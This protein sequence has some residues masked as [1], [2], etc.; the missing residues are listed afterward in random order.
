MKG[1]LQS[2]LAILESEPDNERAL[3]ALEALAPKV[4]EG[5]GLSLEAASRALGT[6]RRVHRERSDWDLVA[7]L[8]DLEL[9]WT[10]EPSRRADLLYE[11]GRV[12]SDELLRDREAVACFEKVLELRP[13]DAATHE[14]LSN[15]SLVRENWE[16]I[17]TR[18]LTE[19][20]QAQD[21]QLAT[22]LY[23]SAAELYIKNQP[24]A[25]Q[26]EAFLRRAL[27]LDPRN[28]KAAAHLERRL[29]ARGAWDE[30]GTLLARRAEGAGSK[31]ERVQA[32]IALAELEERRGDK[33]KTLEAWRRVLSV[34]AASPRALRALVEALTSDAD[35]AALVKVYEAALKA[36]PRGEHEAALVLQIGMLYWKKLSDLDSAEA[37]FRRVRK[38]E[39]SHPVALEFYRA[40]FGARGE[41]Q[42]L[43]AVLQAAAK[44]ETDPDRRLSLAV[45]MARGAEQEAGATEKAIDLWKAVL[46]VDAAG[47]A[48]VH[49]TEASAALRRLYRKTEKWNAL[50][51]LLKDEIESLPADKKAEKIALHLEVAEI[52][53]DKLGLDA[54][55]IGTYQNI[56]AL[57]PG[58]EGA[59]SAL[60]RKYEVLGRWNDLI[61]VVSR[62]AEAAT[63]KAERVGL[64][65]Q[66]ATLWLEKFANANQAVK[67]L[68][69]ILAL[70]PDDPP[71]IAALRDIYA[72]RRSWRALLD[73]DRREL[74][75]LDAA[76]RRARLGQMARLAAERLGDARE[77][78][79]LWNQ[80]L[81]EDE[82]QVA[83]LAAL[84]ALYE[85]EKRWPALCEVLRRQAGLTEE[86]P[87]RV[88]LLE[89]VGT[90]LV[91]RLSAPAQ[92]AE[93]W[94]EILALSPG[95]TK[96]QRTLRELYAQQ[97]NFAEL[98]R[99]YG[100]TG[101]WEELA[102]AL[103]AFVDRAADTSAR[104]L[105]LSRIATIY[106]EK[107]GRPERAVK[108]YERIL[109]LDPGN[110]EAAQAL[111]PIY[112][113]TE[114]WARLLAT[115]EILLGHARAT[116]D[117]LA[118]LREIRLLCEQRLGSKGLAFQWC[119]KAWEL[120]PDD[121]PLTAE[122]ERLAEEAGAWED[123]SG[124]YGR[125]A[126]VVTD[127]V[128]QGALYRR[129]AKI[130]RE[131]TNRPAEARRFWE[132]V[133]ARDGRDAEA[134]AALEQI[135]TQQS[136]WPELAA[137]YRRR[138]EAEA[139]ATRRLE[140]ELRVAFL[141]EERLG[142]LEAAAATYRKALESARA[143]GAA[144]DGQRALTALE[145]IHAA[146]GQW[147]KVVGVLDE[148]WQVADGDDARA[149]LRVQQGGIFEQQLGDRARALAAY[150]DALAAQPAHRGA[151][152]ALERLLD[153]KELAVEA[154]RL[155]LPLY[156]REGD[157]ARLARTLEILHGA[158]SDPHSRLELSLRLATLY[159]RR[160]GEPARAYEHA[161]RVLEK[162][163]ED[164]DLR[165][166]MSGLAETLDGFADYATRLELAALDATDPALLSS[167]NAE[168]AEIYDTRL[169]N[170]QKA[171]EFYAKVAGVADG[172]DR[173]FLALARIYRQ[174][175]R[176]TELRT[177]LDDRRRKLLDPER[178]KELLFQICDL[179]EGV[180]EDQD[181]AVR[182]YR[183][184]LELD[185]ANARAFKA[186]E[187]VLAHKE[188]WSELDA[189]LVQELSFAVGEE[190]A[191]LRFKRAELHATKLG[192]LPGAVDLLQEVLAE[193]PDHDGARRVLERL[194][195]RAELRQR[196][197]AI[198]E[199]YFERDEAWTKLAAV[200]AVRREAL[201]GTEAQEMLARIAVL[202][203]E[204]LTAR[205]AA[206]LTWRE[207]LR[208]DPA[209]ARAR[210]NVARLGTLLE[211]WNELAQA[212]E[213]SFGLA[214][215]GDIA[216]RAE[217]L[218][219]AA[220][221][222]DERLADP[223]RAQGA[224]RRLLDL[225]PQ[226]LVYARPAAAALAEL[227][228]RSGSFPDLVEILRL[229]SAW[230]DDA[231][232]R[233][234]LLS[235][236]ATIQEQKLSNPQAAIATYREVLE[237]EPEDAAA[238]D[239]LERLYTG[240]ASWRD[241]IGILKRRVELSKNPRE[242]R[243]LYWRIAEIQERELGAAAE[244]VDSYLAILDE[245]PDDVPAL[246]QLARLYEAAGRFADLREVLIRELALT[247]RRD[248]RLELLHRLA[249]LAEEKLGRLEVALERWQEILV[250][251]A[252]DERAVAGIERALGD[253]TLK[254]KA[255]EVL[256]PIWQGRGD[257]GKQ[258]M[259]HE[260]LAEAASDPAVRVKRLERAAELKERT[261]DA[262]GAF[263][264]WARA[265]H[266]AVGGPDLAP[267]CDA[268][269]RLAAERRREADLVALYR[270]IGAD[271]LDAGLQQR[272]HLQVADLARTRLGDA[273]TARE[274]YRRVL[275]AAP[276]H[277]RALAALESLYLE[278]EDW[279]P[280]Y[281][282]YQ[283]R[284]ELAAD[285]E[286]KREYLS[287][288]ATLSQERLERPADAITLYEQI[289][290]IAP[291]DHDALAQLERLYEA[292]QRWADLADLLERRLGFAEDLEE[293]V[294]LRYRLGELYERTLRD[295]DRAVENYRA[296]L[297]GEP[298]HTGAIAALE[299]YLE[300]PAQQAA[301]AEVLE[302][303]YAA[304]QDW[305]K[306]VRIYEIR[307]MAAEDA[308]L[309]LQLL[310]RIARLYEEQ[311]E[312]LE[313]AF[314]WYGKVFRESPDDPGAR[315]QLVRLAG[316]L[317]R[318]RELAD[319]Y[320][321]WLND[322]IEP[323]PAWTAVCWTLAGLYDDKL[324][325][326]L[327]A[328]ECYLRLLEQTPDDKSIFE[329]LER[330][331][332]R[333]ARWRDLLDVY[334]QAASREP[335]AEV[336]RALYVKIAR[337]YEECVGD[338]DEAIAT[339]R[340]VLELEPDDAQ[341][342]AALD[343]LLVAEKR[344]HDLVELLT[345]RLGRAE[346]A[347]FIALKF[348]LGTLFEQ[349][350]DDTSGAIDAYE[351]CL[352]RD[353][354]HPEARA[355][356][357][358]LVLERDH[359]FRIAQILEPLYKAQD[360][361]AKLVVIYDAQ[362]EF[363][364]DPVR[365]V[366]ILR[367][368]ARIHETRG[369]NL[370]LA[371]EALARAFGDQPAS[372]ETLAELTR[373]SEQEGRF[374]DLVRV[375]EKAAE[376][377]YEPELSRSLWAQ[378]AALYAERL[379][380]PD[381]AVTAWRKVL[382]ARDDD[383]SALEA[384]S[385]LLEGERRFEELVEVIE[386]RA[387]LTE[388]LSARKEL[389]WRA[390]ALE[391]ETLNRPARAIDLLQRVL[392][393][394]DADPRS[395]DG[396]ERLY[397][398]G[399]DFRALADTLTRKIEL[400]SEAAEKRR[401]LGKLADVYERHIQD[402]YE[403]IGCYKAARDLD[404][405]DREALAALDRLYQAEGLWADL[406]E[407]LEA[408]IAQETDSVAR[409]ELRFRAARVLEEETGDVDSAL[410]RYRQV[411]DAAP[412]H[413]GARD[414]L[415]RLV[416][417]DGTRE[418]A[419]A[420]LEPYLRARK[421]WD[422][423]TEIAEL[424]LEAET[425]PARRRQLLADLAG[426]AEHGRGDLQAAFR[427]WGRALG[428]DAGDAEAQR[429]LERLAA[430][431]GAFADLAALY[432]D[433]L[434]N[435]FDAEIGR[436]LALKLATLYEE[437]LGDAASA[438]DK[439]RQALDF[440]GDERGPLAALDRLL[441]SL[442]RWVE[443]GEVLERE[444]AASLEPTVQA[445]FLYR[446]GQVRLERLVDHDQAIDA[447]RDVLEREPAHEGAL[448]AIAHYLDDATYREQAIEILEPAWEARDDHKNL[449]RLLEVKLQIT[450]EPLERARLLERIAELSEKELDA[451][452]GALDAYARALAEDP[453]ELRY[454]EEVARLGE[455][456][457]AAAEAAA[458]IETVADAAVERSRDA[459]RDLGLRAGG[460]W[461]DRAGDLTRAEA[462]YRKVLE[463]DEENVEALVALERVLR[464]RSDDRGL[465][466]VLRRRA[467]AELDARKKRELYAEA[468]RIAE[469]RLGD[470]Q[471]ALAAWSA[472]VE[473]DESDAD[474]LGELARLH[475][476]DQR[477]RE[478]AETLERRAQLVEDRGQQAALWAR[479]GQVWFERVGEPERA[480]DAYRAALDAQPGDAGVLAALEAVHTA[481]EDWLAVQEVLSQALSQAPDAAARVALYSKLA[482]LA[483]Q[484]RE[485]V[486]EAIGFW[487]Q[488]SEADAG[489]AEVLGE[490]ERLLRSAEKW[491]ELVDVLEK[492]A[493]LDAAGGNQAGE[494]ARLLAISEVWERQIGNAEGAAEIL[495]KV[496][497]RD[498]KN[499]SAITQLA[500]IYEAAG[501]WD[502]CAQA[503]ERAAAL[504]PTGRPAA[505]L[506]FR[507]GRVEAERSGD[508]ARAE[509]HLARAIEFD[510][511]HKEALAALEQLAR[512]RTDWRRVVELLDRRER[513]EEDPA[514]KRELLTE[515]GRL[516]RGE[517]GAAADA[518]PYLERAHQ[519]APDD[520]QILEPLAD[521][522]FHAGRYDDA[523]RLL[524][525]L[526]ERQKGRKSKDMARM[527]FRL[528]AIAE[529]KGDEP[530]ATEHYNAAFA[531]DPTHGATMAALGRLHVKK[532][533]WEKAR[534]VFRSMLLHNLDPDAR[535]SKAD[536]YLELGR[537]HE[538]LGEGPK[539]RN[540]YEC[541]LE[542]DPQ[543]THLK[544]AL[545]A[546]R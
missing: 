117:R 489:N 327:K 380:N 78:I 522:Y 10:N 129:L 33:P 160:L 347:D 449:V 180:L 454:A 164:G 17:A 140:L 546:L 291:G 168:I 128:M 105:L 360:E 532:G 376:S 383:T 99:L 258:I 457:G 19:A 353:A 286:E 527:Q 461:L 153:D 357:E 161:G 95:H 255:A 213:E 464:A 341:A 270:D 181:D 113:S 472:A 436:A 417:A 79:S 267:L 497:A 107:L 25:E 534:K 507:M 359:R 146:L 261:G 215:T 338:A 348:R 32:M 316:I 196:V 492:R 207:A 371:W 167:L 301:A 440:P 96:A 302:P 378:A 432:E 268:L 545:A 228:E 512:G 7:R 192:D 198:L 76:E 524:R 343:R 502:K 400:A 318:W 543:H 248:L 230:A 219:R 162:R 453:T 73:L 176:F 346:G 476:A 332:T 104:L 188:M 288:A 36:R 214:G 252:G 171:A 224:W 509:P 94:R 410:A 390:A 539:A 282:I 144:R 191:T 179:D 281:D 80:L 193:R 71:T 508:E 515:I 428:E 67:P 283:R 499:V 369:A 61:G 34:D 239:A 324:G 138:A 433:R 399:G 407:V 232:G 201:E 377:V 305:P 423:L 478:L 412:E 257:L 125:R 342:S 86:A 490:L 89:R 106:I 271:V 333:A 84:A 206:F 121:G 68:E 223:A 87:A 366:D 4:R 408:R 529:Q 14:V 466:E 6:A 186:L 535:M 102:E 505:E 468:A 329:A 456:L 21:R 141:E 175:E 212:W 197:A 469:Q 13:D 482:R 415:F 114:K 424:R 91:E 503:L 496:L 216:L 124:L 151:A 75:R 326:A 265:A 455:A 314:S 419:A 317:D 414:A 83:A 501:E 242:R 544:E 280:L 170:A 350:L 120:D 387:D 249:Q 240:G 47:Q 62:R 148:R 127:A 441:E 500:R 200:L 303:V 241:Q 323:G 339:W 190:G 35:W 450:E 463:L 460:L 236:I 523:A 259:L 63:D 137:I 65:R 504:L 277:A 513:A 435:Q 349:H 429:E 115:Y 289:L 335:A 57:D 322:T 325:D 108:S 413:T 510:P 320:Q 112:Q 392:G 100:E 511:A 225:D 39:P 211:K 174:E 250:L 488:A 405:N 3:A 53:R 18:Y 276:D 158:E 330:S 172:T 48:H 279:E 2:Y 298:G 470:R 296:T 518:L 22:S 365:R 372:E 254:L 373:V 381:A 20:K 397:E 123:L 12:L 118:L 55:V 409:E 155:L 183:A 467:A 23:L 491:Y 103:L 462:R 66:V 247:D 356:L 139:D 202:Q 88:A 484:K 416:R 345:A 328:R 195:G 439:L 495:E 483:E 152:T 431:R 27:E 217:F 46:R 364:D 59:L 421:E 56:L 154:A 285:S 143:A 284:A 354:K 309:R 542:L 379:K 434:A 29:R 90:L 315:D 310:R 218:E 163:P 368:I 133:L 131:K 336:R 480:A 396:L 475:E 93:V 185:P 426:L 256:E 37:F 287:R 418:A 28:R 307:L 43:L 519:L 294:R 486:D 361:W 275:D 156:E 253:E 1:E 520:P 177:L 422:R 251:D 493:A 465:C 398:Q 430:T 533:D 362:L 16:P 24:D 389:L 337:V 169:G 243:D 221:V 226:N 209:D 536:V 451:R 530:E 194:M 40:Y 352:A 358:R 420:A 485:S 70:E 395:L 474:A 266:E 60:A 166:L 189:L 344:W 159:A 26:G 210:E 427:A 38:V 246:R 388:D 245:L 481:R 537:I 119:A 304:R 8:L 147:P 178:Q 274:Y 74:P 41:G 452:A 204:K 477:F 85:R 442:S 403:A 374:G 49:Q 384:L 130:A 514:K 173:A 134:L 157:A 393:L 237:Q 97:G 402:R 187:R 263:D 44:M 319:V 516:L 132:E 273:Q 351:E 69:E 386:R 272:I 58:H 30:L 11:K 528:G 447:W 448:A 182:A 297:G 31:E 290:E 406:L 145:R 51:E 363:I 233:R 149:G 135:F 116:V 199:P 227:Y 443:L 437:A 425:D 471:A 494:L 525:I 521:G 308:K 540:M 52:Y 538:H 126:E 300:D 203:E 506:Y 231:D 498:A 293:A 244:A 321:G 334:E 45:E 526:I 473:S 401:L 50:L 136:A 77:A 340:R 42:K 444:A 370:R 235:R 5:N 9:A 111:V 375:L 313:H 367:E 517:L 205:Q 299:R 238:L 411:L 385:G 391:E 92:A 220:A 531:I 150:R 81:G 331:L 445:A 306:L 222:Y 355:A 479:A 101:Q 262:D 292:G 278:A 15:L 446:L 110:A 487:M 458:R 234:K 264:A 459:A 54:M 260:L 109:A 98:E 541:G 269:E 208:L 229:Q 184:I 394:D 295:P 142:D 82:N 64:L 438:V 122:L 404:A 382:E 311:L 312:D 72:R 165:R